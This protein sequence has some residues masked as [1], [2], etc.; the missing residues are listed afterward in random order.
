MPLYYTTAP[1][2][3]HATSGTAATQLIAYSC[4]TAASRTANLSRI[5]V[6]AKGTAQDN[7]C[8]FQAWRPTTAN[9]AGTA[10]TPV[11]HDPGAQAATLVAASGS[12]TAG[13]KGTTPSV[14]LAFNSRAYVQWVALNPDESL[15]LQANAAATTGNMDF[16]SEEAAGVAVTLMYSVTHYE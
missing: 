2:A 1:T 15:F 6:G 8:L 10:A 16:Y 14:Q 7:P 11:P 4:R 9:S 12:P 5:G 13:T 3:G